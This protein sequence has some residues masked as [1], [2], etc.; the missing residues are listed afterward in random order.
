MQKPTHFL[1]VDYSDNLTL[2]TAL[3]N[4]LFG[5][6]YFHTHTLLRCTNAL[7]YTRIDV[8]VYMYKSVYIVTYN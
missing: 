5:A 4:W 3:S 2:L 8:C 6:D 7:S 1:Y